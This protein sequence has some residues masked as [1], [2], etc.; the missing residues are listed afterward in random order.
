MDAG[1]ADRDRPTDM[2]ECGIPAHH[3]FEYAIRTERAFT[4][5][6]HDIALRP[7]RR[8]GEQRV[9]RPVR[10]GVGATSIC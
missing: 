7:D 2:Q 3:P 10:P 9:L 8:D 6:T 5:I 1:I 4:D